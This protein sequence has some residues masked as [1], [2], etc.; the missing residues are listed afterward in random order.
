MKTL[1]HLLIFLLQDLKESLKEDML[2]NDNEK[3]PQWVTWMPSGSLFSTYEGT[4][5][6]RKNSILRDGSAKN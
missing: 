5:Y 2:Q 4:S 1:E 3:T 6:E